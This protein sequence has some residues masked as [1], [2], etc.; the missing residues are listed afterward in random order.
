M[1]A[2]LWASATEAASGKL[3]GVTRG[4]VESNCDKA[5]RLATPERC[6]KWRGWLDARWLADKSRVSDT[7]DHRTKADAVEERINRKADVSKERANLKAD[8]SGERVNRSK[9]TG[10]KEYRAARYGPSR[11]R[12]HAHK[13]RTRI[14]YVYAERPP[15]RC[16]EADPVLYYRT[17]PYK[18][19][20]FPTDYV[21]RPGKEAAFLRA[22]EAARQ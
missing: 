21:L 13:V 1:A 7:G 11:H 8:V 19:Q 10:N 15:R 16:C 9:V 12:K 4:W 6:A 2:L 22:Y 5:G 18:D 20:V 14:V 17:S 3:C